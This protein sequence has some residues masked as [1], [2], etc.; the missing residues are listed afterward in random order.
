M[1][2]VAMRYQE[3]MMLLTRMLIITT[4]HTALPDSVYASPIAL[5]G[6]ADTSPTVMLSENAI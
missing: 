6:E 3:S 2:G 1:N 4:A 5:R